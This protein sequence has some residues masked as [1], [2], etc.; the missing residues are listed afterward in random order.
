VEWT[1]AL[2]IEIPIAH[3][4]VMTNTEAPPPRDARPCRL[5]SLPSEVQSVILRKAGR[6]T[7]RV[8]RPWRHSYG[9]LDCGITLRGIRSKGDI[10]LL[11]T[12]DPRRFH[13]ATSLVLTVD[14]DDASGQP[15]QST[16]VTET[17]PAAFPKLRSLHLLSTRV[18]PAGLQA[19]Q[20][21]TPTLTSLVLPGI[22]PLLP[23]VPGILQ[24]SALRSL[25]FSCAQGDI[26]R[27]PE[28]VE[29]FSRLPQLQQLC[30]RPGIWQELR[31]S[32]LMPSLR[33]LGLTHLSLDGIWL[34]DWDSAA[35]DALR[36]ALPRLAAATLLLDFDDDPFANP[37]VMAALAQKTA[38]TT[39]S[40]DLM[41]FAPE[42]HSLGGL[43][44][45]RL[46]ELQVSG[47]GD[48]EVDPSAVA[49]LDA[50]LEAMAV[51]RSLT[52]LGIGP[53]SP[54]LSAAGLQSVRTFAGRLQKLSLAGV[55][56]APDS[57]FL[58]VLAT[59]TRLTRLVFSSMCPAPAGSGGWEA[60]SRQ[61]AAL[62]VLEIKNDDGETIR[63][64][65]QHLSG[66]I[67]L[68]ALRLHGGDGSDMDVA[69]YQVVSQ[70]HSLTRLALS[71]LGLSAPALGGVLCRMTALQR[72]AL[73]ARPDLRY[74]GRLHLHLLPLP[75]ALRALHLSGI[76]GD[77]PAEGRAA[78]QAAAALQDCTFTLTERHR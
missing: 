36:A 47:E 13:H 59:M 2:P 60:A 38:L 26:P 45:L 72:L 39:L 55:Y 65:L 49:K 54:E 46:G 71:V 19:L 22:D 15:D 50:V 8:A 63:A 43:S 11:L 78:L 52:S 27:L 23:H 66:L 61:L 5:T 77:L 40:L 28:A 51:Q 70:K 6:H 73:D 69:F 41:C 7:R 48:A 21:L 29:A 30:L 25:T 57:E 1:Q 74:C 18:T 35:T 37:P 12:R 76:D 9:P 20:P 34:C 67:S 4:P 3:T 58:H 32:A 62:E 64:A 53:V 17:V 24:L 14:R 31:A 68:R 75:P 16:E 33:N 42:H 10:D 56:L 44:A